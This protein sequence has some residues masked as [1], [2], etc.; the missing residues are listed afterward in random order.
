MVEI[1][2]K[3][4]IVQIVQIANR[5]EKIWQNFGLEAIHK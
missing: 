4:K 1:L 3:V 5:V 2:Q